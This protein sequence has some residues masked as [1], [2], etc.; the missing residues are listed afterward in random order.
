[1]A[2][3]FHVTVSFDAGTKAKDISAAFNA[4]DDWVLYAPGNW[5]LFSD[6]GRHFWYERL[7]RFAGDDCIVLVI[8]VD[9]NRMMGYLHM[10]IWNWFE[11]NKMN[12]DTSDD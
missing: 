1:M 8:E 12:F 5:F 11:K 6:Q 10:T 7:R 2:E 4:A 9:P 3:L